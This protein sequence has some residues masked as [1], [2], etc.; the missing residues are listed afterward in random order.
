MMAATRDPAPIGSRRTRGDVA[1]PAIDSRTSPISSE[2]GIEEAVVAASS[3]AGGSNGKTS[4]TGTCMATADGV[5]TPLC[6][7]GSRAAGAKPCVN[8]MQQSAESSVTR[9]IIY[10]DAPVDLAVP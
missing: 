10:R 9:F 5:L 4:A 7:Q 6:A 3:S 2:E 1:K 8:A